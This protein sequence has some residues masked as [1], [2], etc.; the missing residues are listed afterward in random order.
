MK[1]EQGFSFAWEAGFGS[2]FSL[3]LTAL[4]PPGH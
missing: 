1:R 2:I 3:G 4:S